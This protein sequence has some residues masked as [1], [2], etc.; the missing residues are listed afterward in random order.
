MKVSRDEG[1]IWTQTVKSRHQSYPKTYKDR[2]IVQKW[3]KPRGN[4]KTELQQAWVNH[5]SCLADVFKDPEPLQYDMANILR[6]GSRW[7]PRDVFYAAA[8]GQLIMGVGE[9][10]INTPTA[11]LTRTANVAC[12][13]GADTV[14]T[15]TAIEWDNNQFW[16]S[17]T[18]PT[19]MTFKSPGLYLIGA[20]LEFT[21]VAGGSRRA[22]IR[23][24]GSS[25]ISRKEVPGTSSGAQQI[26]PTRIY[27]FSKND[28]IEV[29]YF[30]NSAGVNIKL[31][32][33]WCVA[34]TPEN[35][36]ES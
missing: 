35:V 7:L 4:K 17:V 32:T 5:F 27:Y 13:N 26:G 29:G 14:V 20:E 16:S 34:I 18:N 28:Y 10:K 31:N 8:S 11:S 12:A 6:P 9:I 19:R 21:A 1:F 33:L 23:L 22:W 3:P 2:I 25:F 24:N 36:H 30:Q 15:P